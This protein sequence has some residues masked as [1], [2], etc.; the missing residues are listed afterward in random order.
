MSVGAQPGGGFCLPVHTA[1]GALRRRRE[2]GQAADADEGYEYGETALQ[3]PIMLLSI[4]FVAHSRKIVLGA[5][6]L[7]E[8]G[9]A[10]ALA[11]AGGFVLHLAF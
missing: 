10:M 7:A 9:I 1:A 6:L 3:M 11:I 2:G 8:A 5:I 4:A